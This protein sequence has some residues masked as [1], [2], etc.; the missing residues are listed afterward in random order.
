MLGGSLLH[1]TGVKLNRQTR[2]AIQACCLDYRL[3]GVV[4]MIWDIAGGFAH[5]TGELHFYLLPPKHSNCVLGVRC[6]QTD[7]R[8]RNLIILALS[9]S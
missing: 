1:P 3:P 6:Q 4:F 9:A 8:V 7:D 5:R 2:S